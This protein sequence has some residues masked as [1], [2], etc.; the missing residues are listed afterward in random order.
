MEK[1]GGERIALFDNIKGI[2]IIL[3]VLGHIAHPTVLLA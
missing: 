1:R 2:L 3:V